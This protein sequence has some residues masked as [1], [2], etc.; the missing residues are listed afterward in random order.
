MGGLSS[1][2]WVIT[3]IGGALGTILAALITYLLRKRTTPSILSLYKKALRATCNQLTLTKEE[4]RILSRALTSDEVVE[5]IKTEALGPADEVL[6]LCEAIARLAPRTNRLSD[7]Q[8]TATVVKRLLF[9]ELKVAGRYSSYFNRT[10]D[11]R[12]YFERA[13]TDQ[14]T[15]SSQQ[16]KEISASL[17]PRSWTSPFF[18]KYEYLLGVAGNCIGRERD[19]EKLSADL[20]DADNRLIVIEGFG[21]IGKTTIAARLAT[22]AVRTYNVLWVECQGIAV[23]TERFLFE[24]GHLASEQYKF[25][26]LQPIIENPSL[27][28]T[29]K[30]SGFIEFLSST[31]KTGMKQTT[32]EIS[33]P[34]ALFFDDYHLVTD[35]GLTRFIDRITES[36]VNVKVVLVTRKLSRKLQNRTTADNTILLDGLSLDDC[37]SFITSYVKKFPA[38]AQVDE[39]ML[40]RIWKRT[41]QGVPTALKILASMTRTRSL[42]DVLQQLPDYNPLTAAANEWFGSLFAELAHD[43]QQVATEVSIFRRPVT[44]STLKYISRSTNTDEVIDNLV[45]RFVLMFDGQRYSMHPLWSEHARRILTPIDKKELHTRAAG[46]Y[47]DFTSDD[48]YA[49]VMSKVESCYHFIG[50]ENLV[51][52]VEVILPIA[53]T[54]RFWGVYQELFD[55]LHTVEEFAR[56]VNKPLDPRL[57]I[58]QG[59]T[60]HALGKVESAIAVLSEL[61]ETEKGE[62]Q[63]SALQE[64]GWIYIETGEQRKAEQLL[65]QSL[66]LARQFGLPRLQAEALYK[67]QYNAYHES[68]FTEVLEYNAQRL[69]IFQ[70]MKDDPEAR[71]VIAWIYHDVGNVY[72]EQGR[73]EDA[74]KLYLQSLDIWH[75]IGESAFRVG[76]LNYDIGQIYRDQG[77]YQEALQRFEYALQTFDKVK[78]IYGVAH[79][80][81]E[82]GRVGSKLDQTSKPIEQVEEGV[83]I[84][85]QLKAP[86]GEAYAL[87]ALGDIYLNRNQPEMALLCLQQSLNLNIPLNN[88]KDIAKSLHRLSLAYEQQGKQLSIAHRHGEACTH[89]KEA[90]EKI[91]RA[92]ELLTQIQAVANFEGIVDDTARIRME[93][94]ECKDV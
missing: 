31:G 49:M 7:A 48:R 77:K 33:L 10:H 2:A 26:W 30:I 15:S 22:Y 54:L 42:Q 89:F 67:L 86:A 38:L 90:L 58:Q 28:E 14:N 20:M 16:E 70:E 51:D 46:F 47:R 25:P 92:Q 63:I 4:R 75:E 36:Y 32:D 74:L 80:K 87:N 39:E 52:A 85:R 83:L 9:E 43:E 94:A 24:M 18:T 61:I 27:S 84:L 5:V 65:I 73:Y 72:R 64:L 60:L 50:A 81:T 69:K 88:I 79:A 78:Y 45:D 35:P 62:V 55:I 40:P 91:S 12:S 82:L 93:C 57:R 21:G 66:Q 53:D 11:R 68:K 6:Q 41:G 17:P 8:W 1:N 13:K 71:E 56:H 44:R 59:A 29:E 76:W 19:I 23:T 3:V 37:R 34:L